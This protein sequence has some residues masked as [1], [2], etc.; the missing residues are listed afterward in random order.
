M[1]S[2]ILL[3]TDLLAHADRAM[4]RAAL[5]AEAAGLPLDILHVVSRELRTAP[6]LDAAKAAALAS[7]RAEIAAAELPAGLSVTPLVRGGEPGPA[8]V[9]AAAEARSVLVVLA[10]QHGDLLVRLFRGSALHHAVR[11][12]PC[13]VLLVRR[14]ARH[15]YRRIVVAVDLSLPSRLALD[16]ALRLMPGAGMAQ[17]EL[18]LV[19][20]GFVGAPPAAVQEQRA[21]VDDMLV[22]S[23]ARLAAEGMAPPGSIATVMETGG[24][25]AVVAAAAA[26]RDAEL[27]VAG[28]TGLTG[29]ANLLLGS[30]AEALL[31]TLPCDV[32]AVRPVA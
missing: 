7:L 20:A 19:H 11:H 1:T 27:V 24:A 6:G 25:V 32:L 17:V 23:L 15:A 26:A 22:A 21:R 16:R 8:I 30:V 3:A 12:A 28:T 10:A 4:D 9:A 31:A 5:I 13:P 29:A 14:R 18:T 2:G